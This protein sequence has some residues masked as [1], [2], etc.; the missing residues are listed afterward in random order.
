MKYHLNFD[1]CTQFKDA[2]SKKID[3]FNDVV[4]K[5]F[6]SSQAVEWVGLG[7]DKTIDVVYNQIEEL[8][9]I[10]ENLQKF[11]KFLDTAMENFGE[12]VGEVNTKFAEI[13][14][15]INAE[16]MKRGVV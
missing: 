16:K 9:K 3:E 7:H 1:D 5:L 12:G 11:I 15:V 14:E 10:S 4:Y 13:K 2:F 6:K 8:M